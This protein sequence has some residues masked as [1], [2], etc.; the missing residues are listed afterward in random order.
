MGE[1]N[2][3]SSPKIA[4]KETDINDQ[5]TLD[6]NFMHSEIQKIIDNHL[7]GKPEW[8]SVKDWGMESLKILIDLLTW[9]ITRDD[10]DKRYEQDKRELYKIYEEIKN[11]YNHMLAIDNIKKEAWH[12]LSKLEP[13]ISLNKDLEQL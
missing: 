7:K 1:K 11:E 3:K 2:W 13:E 10:I 12:E 8:F 4:E 9:T 5:Y 6:A